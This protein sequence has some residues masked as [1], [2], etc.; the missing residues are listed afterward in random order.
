MIQAP[1]HVGSLR[2]VSLAPAYTGFL[3]KQQRNNTLIRMLYLR[4]KQRVLPLSAIMSLN[5]LLYKLAPEAVQTVR[6]SCTARK[7]DGGLV[8][9]PSLTIQQ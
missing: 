7:P 1:D 9:T 4:A 6:G 2:Q 5:H 3:G 8:V